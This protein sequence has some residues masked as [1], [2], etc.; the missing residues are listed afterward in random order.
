MTTY[1]N[2]YHI[3]AKSNGRDLN[4]EFRVYKVME[5]LSDNIIAMPVA[6]GG[7]PMTDEPAA[8]FDI[9]RLKAGKLFSNYNAALKYY[10][11]TITGNLPGSKPSRVPIK[12]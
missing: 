2:G 3:V 1:L 4:S 9:T 12:A 8:I 10:T 7:E 5:Q 11:R 6:T